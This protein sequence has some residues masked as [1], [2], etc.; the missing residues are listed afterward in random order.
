MTK[1]INTIPINISVKKTRTNLRKDSAITLCTIIGNIGKAIETATH[2]K[3]TI[4]KYSKILYSNISFNF[5][6]QTI[7]LIMEKQ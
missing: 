1:Y 4:L 2:G 7:W 6:K 3:I 5:D